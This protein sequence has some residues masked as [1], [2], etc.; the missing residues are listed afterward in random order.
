[1]LQLGSVVDG[2]ISTIVRTTKLA[3]L[4]EGYLTDDHSL[5]LLLDRVTVLQKEI[6]ELIGETAQSDPP[7]GNKLQDLAIGSQEPLA[8]A[9]PLAKAEVRDAE[10]CPG[11]GNKDTKP[12]AAEYRPQN[13]ATPTTVV[14][15]IPLRKQG[16]ATKE[17]PHQ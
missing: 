1:M 4:P 2:R 9:G 15:V 3:E 13:A 14:R 6:Y 10:I 16:G 17:D 12:R 11:S 5:K 7:T 8:I